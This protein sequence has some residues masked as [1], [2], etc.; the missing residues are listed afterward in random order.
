LGS[1]LSQRERRDSNQIS[2][3]RGEIADAAFGIGNDSW[4]RLHV[5]VGRPCDGARVIDLVSLD[6][7]KW[8]IALEIPSDGAIDASFTFGRLFD[9]AD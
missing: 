6:D 5:M 1:A 8:S 7:V 2:F 9:E 4:S 3:R